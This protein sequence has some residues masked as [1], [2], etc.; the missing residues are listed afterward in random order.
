MSRLAP[1]LQQL[2]LGE[3]LAALEQLRVHRHNGARA[4]RLGLATLIGHPQLTELAAHH[5]HRVVRVLKHFCGERTWSAARRFLTVRSAV[6]ERF[7]RSRLLRFAKQPDAAREALEFLANPFERGTRGSHR[8]AARFSDAG[9][10]RSAAARRSLTEPCGLPQQTL[11]GIAGTY[12]PNLQWRVVRAFALPASHRAF[13]DGP[14]TEAIKAALATP[15][16]DPTAALPPVT[17]RS[18]DLLRTLAAVRAAVILDFSGS[19]R[20]SGERLNHPAALGLALVRALE[21]YLP[22]LEVY[23]TGGSAPASTLQLPRPAGVGDLATALINAARRNPT[24][25]LIV[26]DGYETYRHA[27][28][29]QVVAGLRKLGYT[30]PITQVTPVIST[31]EDLARRRL[32]DQIALL[33]VDHEDRAG[34]LASRLLL[35]NYAPERTL[36]RELLNAVSQWLFAS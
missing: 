36:D 21:A 32:G 2:V 26:T 24:A 12:H 15:Q 30:L 20:S 17:R 16:R 31:S 10:Q 3:L 13:R 29:A 11:A 7:L 22:R 23:Q 25:L 5:R 9:L 19:M 27:D 18:G 14:L 1:G 35:A 34:E 8:S 33:A 4:R 28:V 6:G